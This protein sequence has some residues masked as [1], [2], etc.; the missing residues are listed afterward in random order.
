MTVGPPITNQTS[1]L[2][3]PLSTLNLSPLPDFNPSGSPASHIAPVGC[4]LILCAQKPNQNHSSMIIAA[5]TA[6]N[7]LLLPGSPVSTFPVNVVGHGN[8]WAD[9]KYSSCFV[10]LSHE[11][12]CHDMS[13]RPDLLDEWRNVLQAKLPDWRIEWAPHVKG[14]D[15]M[16]QVRVSV[17]SPI[18]KEQETAFAEAV[19][20]ALAAK[21]LSVS[22]CFFQE[23]NSVLVTFAT[24]KDH[25]IASSPD[26]N[27]IV[28]AGQPI[29]LSIAPVWCLRIHYAFELVVSGISHCDYSYTS[30]L[31]CFFYDINNKDNPNI[32]HPCTLSTHIIDGDF[33]CI[34]IHDW[35]A[36]K[37]ALT[38]TNSF[39]ANFAA[40]G[41]TPPCLL[42]EV[43]SNGSFQPKS[44]MGAIKDM[45][46]AMSKDLSSVMNEV[47][48]LYSEFNHHRDQVNQSFCTVGK[49]LLD[50]SG[51]V[52]HLSSTVDTLEGRISQNTLAIM[53][54]QSCREKQSLLMA[55][56]LEIV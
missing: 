15:K 47:H 13:R 55:L 11:A 42:Y 27:L 25:D 32:D 23:P 52:S 12:A 29:S 46:S 38:S 20:Q 4:E 17:N 40:Q 6:V 49:Q 3:T 39:I 7:K 19:K 26:F 2:Q 8:Q 31:K 21:G 37:H 54:E 18:P 33:F 22:D 5:Q 45:S 51:N 50:I 43:N 56:E 36:T 53:D 48:S 10:K 1:C 16:V 30:Q 24:F 44:T 9:T 41:I 28:Q 14:K 35:E 34:I